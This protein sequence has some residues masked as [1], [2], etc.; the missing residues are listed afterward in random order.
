VSRTLSRLPLVLGVAV[1]ALLASGVAFTATVKTATLVLDGQAREVAFRGDT[2]GDMLEAAGLSAGEHDLLVPAVTSDLEDGAQVALRRGRQVELVIDGAPQ[3]VWVTATSVD[4]VL[5]QIG[6]REQN[7]AL[8]ASR[9]REIPLDG[10]RLEVRTPK[11]IAVLV[12][13]AT[14]ERDTTAVTVGDALAE[15]GVVTDADDRLSVPASD[16]VTAGLQIQVFRVAVDR[17]EQ[18]V[19]TPFETD[20]RPDA[21]LL[22]GESKE[23]TA[24]KEGLVRNT[25][26]R[27]LV[28]GVLESSTVLTST[29]ITAPVTRVVAVGTKPRPPAPKP[30]PAPAPAP[31]TGTA[32]ADGLNW[33]ALARCESGGNPRAVS[34]GGRYR[35]LYQFSLATWRGVGGSGDPID[36]SA[37]EQLFR[38]KVLYNRSGAGQWPSCGRLLFT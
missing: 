24:G 3:Q 9:S 14:Q 26:K 23:L 8:S 2:V 36:N 5:D 34:S 12:D 10:L 13:N 6:L 20:G 11:R 22:E 17:V 7:L 19:A 31:R 25:V 16:P 15:A 28:D 27:V 37:E 35:G 30:A 1:T 38:A 21:G 33:P 32:G 29:P 18:D 4:E